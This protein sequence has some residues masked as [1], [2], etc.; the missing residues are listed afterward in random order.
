MISNAII[1]I[2][3]RTVPEAGQTGNPVY[4]HMQARLNNDCWSNIHFIFEKV[5]DSRYSAMALA[6]FLSEGVCNSNVVT[7][8][9]TVTFTPG[10]AG[11]YFVTFWMSERQWV[12]DTIRITTGSGGK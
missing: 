1:P 12:T 2:N 9:T 3:A 7:G 8:D 10:V 6:D 4:I 5:D 11:D